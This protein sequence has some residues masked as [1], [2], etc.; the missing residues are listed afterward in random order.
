MKNLS[1]TLWLV[2]IL[3]MIGGIYISSI[4]TDPEKEKWDGIRAGVSKILVTPEKPVRMSGYAAR[5]DPFK[6]VHDDLYASAIV[7]D[8]G[9][10][11][12]CLISVD[13]IGFSNDFVDD[14]KK[15]ITKSTGVQEDFILLAAAH[16]HGGPT[17]RAYGGEATNNEKEYAEILQKKIVQ[18]A[19]EANGKLQSVRIGAGKGSCHMNINRRANHADGGIWLGR[20]PEGVCDTD[21]GV[22]RIDNMQ[23]ETIAV[24]VNWPCHAT[25]GGQQNYQITGDWPGATARNVE[26]AYEGAVVLVT[27]GASGDINP[28]YG[29]NDNF[30]DINAI[31]LTLGNEVIRVCKEI[32]T[33]SHKDIKAISNPVIAKGKKRSENRM[34]NVSLEPGDDVEIRMASIKIGNIV[35]SGISG[36]LMNEIGL[37]AKEDSPYKY[38]FIVSNSNGGSG[39]LCTDKAYKEGGYEP[40]SARTMPGT[41]KL[42]EDNFKDMNNGL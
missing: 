34:P 9:E 26:K 20:N 14:T 16:N 13:V 40:M 15:M 27:A 7:F 37:K 38:T 11:K 23:S 31:G 32:E 29:P 25:T 18:I 5:K 3:F 24:W 2:A 1:K 39:Y 12:A 36:E 17:T 33:Y 8:N 30:S 35:I 19:K 6:G 21:V 4:Q 10:N 42:I 41:Q 28:V 22:I